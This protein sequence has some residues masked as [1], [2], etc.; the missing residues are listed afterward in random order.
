[1]VEMLRELAENWFSALPIL[2][3]AQDPA[4]HRWKAITNIK[5]KGHWRHR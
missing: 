4:L 1:M 5:E 3:R 2:A